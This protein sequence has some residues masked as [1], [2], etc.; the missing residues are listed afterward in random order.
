MNKY[1]KTETKLQREQTGGCQWGDRREGGQ[2]RYGAKR[3]T[4]LGKRQRIH[5][6]TLCSRGKSPFFIATLSGA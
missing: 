4:L 2:N 5:E 3:Y 1:N 6:D